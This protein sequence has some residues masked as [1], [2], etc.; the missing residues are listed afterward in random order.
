M[1]I[2]ER[3][4]RQREDDVLWI[5]R[6][7]ENEWPLH[8]KQISDY[9]LTTFD[10]RY[11]KLPGYWWKFGHWYETDALEW[12]EYWDLGGMIARAVR[13]LIKQ[14]RITS[15]MVGAYS[16]IKARRKQEAERDKAVIDSVINFIQSVGRFG[17][18]PKILCARLGT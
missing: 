17:F 10:D 7:L 3:I 9:L 16:K 1:A 15:D 11:E 13:S 12:H 6:K 5:V 18:S 8:P 4:M 2:P 14:G